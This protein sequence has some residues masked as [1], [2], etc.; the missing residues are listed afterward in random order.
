MAK[1]IESKNDR[2]SQYLPEYSDDHTEKFDGFMDIQPIERPTDLLVA[3]QT[4]LFPSILPI[5][6]PMATGKI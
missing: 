1:Y 3:L 5:Y 2:S 6:F 4:Y